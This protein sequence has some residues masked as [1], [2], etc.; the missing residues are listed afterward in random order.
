MF[1]PCGT[2]GYKNPKSWLPVILV[3]ERKHK[4]CGCKKGPV[5]PRAWSVGGEAVAD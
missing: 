5:D 3:V 2:G 1:A 4:V